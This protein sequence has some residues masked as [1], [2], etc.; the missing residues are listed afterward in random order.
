[1]KII[2]IEKDIH[3]MYVTATTFPAGI[4]EAFDKLHHKIPDTPDRTIY[5]ISR[6]E[7][8]GEIVYRAGV[9]ALSEG[10]AGK[11]QIETLVLPKGNY[12][13]QEATHIQQDA[14]VLDRTFQ[15]LLQHPDLDPQG[16]CVEKYSAGGNEA[17]CMI[18]LD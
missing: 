9:E 17:L 14:L 10:E 18:R 13:S 11:Y 3:I 4:K 2:T 12:I 16:Y 1:M 8:G 15:Q 7:A 5:G 6:P